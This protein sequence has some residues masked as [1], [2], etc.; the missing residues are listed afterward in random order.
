[1][2]PPPGTLQIE[3]HL[4]AGA[5]SSSGAVVQMGNRDLLRALADG[6]ASRFLPDAEEIRLAYLDPP[7]MSG[8][9]RTKP[10]LTPLSWRDA[11]LPARIGEMPVYSDRW[12]SM[13]DYL[14]FLEERLLLVREALSPDGSVYLH[15]DQRV[16]HYAKVMMDRVFGRENFRNEIV[17]RY[18]SG[19]VAR[20]HFARKHDTILFYTRSKDYVFHPQK[21]RKPAYREAA[22]PDGSDEKGE[23]VWYIRPGTNPQVPDGVR[24]YLDG[25]VSDVWYIP[26]VNP[27]A[28]ERIGTGI[29]PTQKPLDLL[30]RI[31]L[32]SSDEGDVV[33]DP[34]CGSGTTAQASAELGRRFVCTDVSPLAVNVTLERLVRRGFGAEIH[35]PERDC[36]QDT[37]EVRTRR[38]P[39]GVMLAVKNVSP[40]VPEEFAEAFLKAQEALGPEEFARSLLQLVS[41]GSM[42]AGGIFRGGAEAA[43]PFFEAGGSKRGAA[44][45]KRGEGREERGNR[46]WFGPFKCSEEGKAQARIFDLLGQRHS[47]AFSG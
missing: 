3:E 29:F 44:G 18:V 25:Y 13:E 12:H 33:L 38:L 42:E 19:G 39:E 45:N 1:M 46:R 41:V 5:V 15:L 22:S 7:F 14:A 20:R 28:R 37:V 47:V 2:N 32:A 30:R 4:P 21:E 10:F 35:V 16:S 24:K 17:W 40:A 27:Q 31:M 43:L 8:R 36:G 34:F 23:F 26:V 9:D 11:G 6:T